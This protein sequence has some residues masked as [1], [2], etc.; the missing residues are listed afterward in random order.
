MSDKVASPPHSGHHNRSQSASTKSTSGTR[1]I[2][3]F[4][5]ITTHNACVCVVENERDAMTHWAGS[6]V[7]AQQTHGNYTN[8]AQCA[9]AFASV[10]VFPRHTTCTACARS[11]I[12]SM[13]CVRTGP[14]CTFRA[15][16]SRSREMSSCAGGI[17]T[18]AAS[19]VRASH[20]CQAVGA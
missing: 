17:V 11:I 8:L 1:S 3:L 18:W 4:T 14:A 19:I 2:I 5:S 10:C 9:S 15:S 7:C 20:V 13:A 16:V 6:R 12:T